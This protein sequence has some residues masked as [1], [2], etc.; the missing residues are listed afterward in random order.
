MKFL[1]ILKDSLRETIDAKV[2]YVMVGLSVLL[3]LLAVSV[4]FAPEPGAA[5]VVR[6]YAV[7]PLNSDAA[8]LESSRA[9]GQLFNVSPVQ[10]TV[11]SVE[12]LDGASDGPGSRFRVKLTASFVTAAAAAD[13]QKDPK[14]LEAF[15]RE[16]FGRIEGSRMMEPEEVRVTGWQGMNLPVPGVNLGGRKANVEVVAGPTPATVRFWPHK[17]SLFFGLLPLGWASAPLFE[18]LDAVENGLVG[19]FGATIAVLVSVII[20]AFFIPNMLRKGSVDM[21]L[22]KPISRPT[23][24]VYKFIGGLTFIFL[25]TAVAVGLVWAALGVRSGVWAIAFL[26]TVLALTFYFAILYSVSTLFGVLTR[27]P[28]AAI[29][30]TIGV[31]FGLFIVGVCHN[32]FETFRALD[33]TAQALHEKLGDEGLAKLQGAADNVPDDGPGKGRPRPR[34]EE[35]RFHENFLTRGISAL[36]R[37][38]PR[39]TEFSQLTKRYLRHDLAFG[40]VR[41]PADDDKPPPELPGGIPLPQLTPPRPAPAETLGVSAAFIA[42]MLGLSCWR[43]ATRDY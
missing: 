12:P 35:M 23:L 20:T 6:D 19:G 43:F 41:A 11:D 3:G 28:I 7:L 17:I 40:E 42:V 25:N 36:H 9:F 31:W 21:L 8:D 24:L 27:S 1:A 13:A 30:L 14:T 38:L 37:V 18:Q 15:L 32:L 33:R 26:L 16:R 34:L 4:T 29:L 39:T 10:F 22:V 5:R 2:F